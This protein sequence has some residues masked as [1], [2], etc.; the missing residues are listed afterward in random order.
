[1]RLARWIITCSAPAEWR[2]S[3]VGDLCE[4]QGRRRTAGRY[5]GWAW[6][7]LAAIGLARALRRAVTTG[8][9]NGGRARLMDGVWQDVRMS[10]RSL[11]ATPGV[12][13]VAILVLALGI[14]AGTAIY[15]VVDAVLLRPLPFEDSDRL[16]AVGE[17]QK[18]STEPFWSVGAAA[19]PTYL[20]WLEMQTVF[21][22]MGAH[23][24]TPGF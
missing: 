14:G 1:M 2:E 23:R 24:F 9:V 19:A 6:S 3:L 11:R 15:S 10:V 5:A 18:T 17:R 7:A 13:A 8:V 12:S 4:K 16:L 20:D 21:Q 22:S